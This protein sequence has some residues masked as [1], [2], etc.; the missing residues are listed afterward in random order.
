MI[1]VSN[2]FPFNLN[3]YLL[4]FAIVVGVCFLVMFFIL[5]R[6]K[7]FFAVIFGNVTL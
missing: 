1:Y 3:K 5:V 4:P 2:E 7:S 6:P